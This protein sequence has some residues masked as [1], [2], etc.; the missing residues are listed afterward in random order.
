M[1]ARDRRGLTIRQAATIQFAS[2][3][4]SFA[5]QF[6]IAMIL[7]R[8]ITPEEFGVVAVI[9]VFTHFFSLVSDMGV[10]AGIVQHKDLD[11]RDISGLML[12]SI[13][14]GV[15]LAAFFCLVTP[16]ISAAYEMPQLTPLGCLVPLSLM[17]NTFAA[18]PN[19]VMLR[20]K[21]FLSRGILQLSGNCAAG[22]FAIVLAF[23]GAGC[24]A[25]V[26][27]SIVSALIMFAGG[28][29]LSRI[30]FCRVL[31]LAPVKK[32]FHFRYFSSCI[33]WLTISARI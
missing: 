17:L 27:Q 11:N 6:V 18:V 23:A 21:R 16:V 20:D 8:L 19:G 30:R 15:G 31:L 29:F 22:I 7:A 28:L 14:V 24:Y 10:S 1:T 12:F 4:S 33:D 5:V 13:L 3:Y 2:R 26:S 9:A 32:S 25:L